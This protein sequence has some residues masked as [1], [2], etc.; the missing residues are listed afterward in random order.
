M[1]F[2]SIG[3][4]APTDQDRH[5]HV[6]SILTNVEAYASY[7]RRFYAEGGDQS[8]LDTDVHSVNLKASQSSKATRGDK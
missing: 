7:L 1:R 3:L 6:Q 8:T 4:P 5:N 2:T